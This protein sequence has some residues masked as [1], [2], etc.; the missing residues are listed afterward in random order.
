MVMHQFNLYQYVLPS[1]L[2]SFEHML[3]YHKKKHTFRGVKAKIW[4][5]KST[6]GEHMTSPSYLSRR[7]DYTT[8][9]STFVYGLVLYERDGHDLVQREH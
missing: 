4:T 2:M 6:I 1:V 3:T 8:L 5:E 7:P 9:L